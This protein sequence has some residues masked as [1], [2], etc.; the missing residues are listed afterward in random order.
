MGCENFL[1]FV[2][3]AIVVV[4]PFSFVIAFD[5]LNYFCPRN[6][7]KHLHSPAD[8]IDGNIL[9]QA[10]RN[11]Q[12]IRDIPF[13]TIISVTFNSMPFFLIIIQSRRDIPTSGENNTVDIFHNL[14]HIGVQRLVAFDQF[15]SFAGQHSPLVLARSQRAIFIRKIIGFNHVQ[16]YYVGPCLLCSYNCTFVGDRVRCVCPCDGQ[17]DI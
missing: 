6:H 10:I 15:C 11:K 1:I 14:C 5:I 9:L 4:Q 2:A 3:M 13:G 17:I 12:I 16:K 8:A 7:G